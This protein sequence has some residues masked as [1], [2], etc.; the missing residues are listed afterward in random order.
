MLHEIGKATMMRQIKTICCAGVVDS[1]CWLLTLRFWEEH[2]GLA[3]QVVNFTAAGDSSDMED[4][5]VE[6]LRSA[7]NLTLAFRITT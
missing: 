7:S 1:K 4:C 3:I 5:V 2:L 6:M